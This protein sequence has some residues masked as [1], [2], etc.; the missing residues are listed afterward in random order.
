MKHNIQFLIFPL[1]LWIISN[2]AI[3]Q[4]STVQGYNYYD[5]NRD[6]FTV[7]MS[8]LDANEFDIPQMEYFFTSFQ[9]A[10]SL[11]TVFYQ[12]ESSVDLVVGDYIIHKRE[13]LNIPLGGEEFRWILIRP[14]DDVVRSV[15]HITHGGKTGGA[16]PARVLSLG[17]FDY[18]QRG[19]AVVYY[20]SGSATGNALQALTDAGCNPA[21]AEDVGAGCDNWSPN[22]DIDCFQQAVFLKSQFARAAQDYSAFFS[23]E[24]HLDTGLFFAQGFSG[25]AVGTLTSTLMDDNNFTDE[26]FADMQSLSHLSLHPNAQFTLK[27]VTTL[28]GGILDE[29]SENYKIGALIDASDTGVRFLMFHG[30]DDYA[31]QPNTAPLLWSY[32]EKILPGSKIK[33]S[34]DLKAQFD[35]FGITNKVILNCSACHDVYTYP[36]DYHDDCLGN[37]PLFQLAGGFSCLLW[38]AEGEDLALNYETPCSSGLVY[39]DE[40]F[41]VMAQIHDYSKVAAHYFHQDFTDVGP[42]KVDDERIDELLATNEVSALNP[43][44]FPYD[45]AVAHNNGHLELSDKC[46][47]QNCVGLYFDRQGTATNLPNELG[48]NYRGDYLRMPNSFSGVFQGDFTLEMNF[49]ALGQTANA[50]LFSMLEFGLSG[51]EIRINSEGYLQFRKNIGNPASITGNTLVLDGNCHHLALTKT[52]NLYGLYL[53]GQLQEVKKNFNITLPNLP[54]YRL[55]NS[56]NEIIGNR[57]FNGFIRNVKLWNIEISE[58]QQNQVNWPTNTPNLLA[59]WTFT[60]GQ[61]QVLTST[62]GQYSINLGTNNFSGNYDP[63]WMKNDEMCAC[64]GEDFSSVS[65]EILN[66]VSPVLFPNPSLGKFSLKNVH[67]PIKVQVFSLDGKLIKSLRLNHSQGIAI[68]NSGFYVVK[69]H[70]GNKTFTQ[71]LV[72]NNL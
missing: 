58:S 50:V 7:D 1:L 29:S 45:A 57:G 65:E 8:C 33:A 46:L 28:A 14:N 26:M 66:R 4:I 19:Y 71:K 44:D 32:P 5:I 11:K 47:Q 36:C 12:N 53:D 23:D 18:V 37:N 24:F 35:A 27:A 68:E 22:C 48:L 67:Y 64:E 42:E 21:C 3:A 41:Y 17:V 15:I 16:D 72:I 31:V 56:Q 69:I 10:E 38:K 25:G 20:Q 54:S 63:K 13:Y 43:T 60:E 70:E 40:M 2:S 51:I 55:G 9:L 61:G 30:Q 39:D 52:G 59:E 62:N 49:K 34:L 6:A